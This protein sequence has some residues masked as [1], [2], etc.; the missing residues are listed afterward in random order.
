M[1]RHPLIAD[2]RRPRVRRRRVARRLAEH[3][4]GPRR[5]LGRP[6]GR[7]LPGALGV[8]PDP[9]ARP[10]R[11]DRVFRC[12]PLG[13]LADLFL[14]DTRTRRDEPVG[15]AAMPRPD[16]TAARPEQ[17]R[18]APRRARSRR[19]ARWR[20]L[21]NASVLGHIWNDALPESPVKA[22]RRGQAHRTA[23][24]RARRRPVG[25]LPGRS[26]RRSCAHLRDSPGATSSC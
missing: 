3:D 22:A 26:A 8:A 15:G 21:G 2:A 24:A 9:A 16:R 11:P 4:D 23:M 19:R 7:R 18:L 17:Q 1:P 25:R 20:I 14:I 12:V 13:D 5:A 10:G 6:Q